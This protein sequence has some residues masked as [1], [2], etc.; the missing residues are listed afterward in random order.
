MANPSIF[1][2][3]ERMWQHIVL[4]LGGKADKT[5]IAQSDMNQNDESAPDYVKNKTHWVEENVNIELCDHDA[6]EITDEC[7]DVDITEPFIIGQS[8]TIIVNGTTY[9]L[10]ARYYPIWQCFMIGNDLYYDVGESDGID[11]DVPFCIAWYWPD[12]T[13][14]ELYAPIGTYSINI[15][16]IRNIYHK[17]D[18]GFLPTTIVG[19]QVSEDGAEIFN[20]YY[21]N[22]ATGYMS[23]AEGETTTASGAWSHAEG[24]YTFANGNMSHTEGYGTIAEKQTSHAEGH[25]TYAYD[26]SH[27][28]G[29]SSKALGDTSHTEGN[30]TTAYGD[31]SHAEGS[32]KRDYYSCEVTGAAGSVTYNISSWSTNYLKT[33]RI[34]WCIDTHTWAKIISVSESESTVTLDQTL[35]KTNPLDN[36]RIRVLFGGAHGEASHSEGKSTSAHSDYQHVQ[37]KYNVEDFDGKYAHIVG[38][39]TAVNKLSNAHTLDWSGNAW[40]AGEIKVGGTGQDDTT[41]KTLATTEYI[42]NKFSTS[43]LN[44]LT[45]G[46]A[47]KAG[48]AS[49]LDATGVAQV[50]AIKVDDATTA[51]K[52]A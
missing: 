30:E 10:T 45:V 16:T 14:V 29:L 52:V 50:K 27:A 19:R 32:C 11:S 46:N 51:D 9:N 20:D 21:K 13:G 15:S 42:D 41:A 22:R 49:S 44:T 39:G 25:E 47:T 1:A 6:L 34:I 40:F 28:E 48:T 37:G 35:D 24:N 8:Y 18:E 4:A 36:A 23:H 38:N 31:Y 2:A 43:N 3:F 12:D 33:G 7:V 26:G 17:L 5:D